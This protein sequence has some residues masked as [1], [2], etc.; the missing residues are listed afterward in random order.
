MTT[1]TSTQTNYEPTPLTAEHRRVLAGSMVGTTIEWFDFFIYAQAA[2]LIFAAQYFNPASNSSPALAQIVSW[3]SIGISFLFRP[4]GAV[5]AG[6]LGDRLGR[7]IVLVLTL[8]G[9]GGAT[10]AMGLLPN[11]AA[12]GIAAPL[13]LVVLRIIQGLSAGGE[14]GGA[15]LLAVE[16]APVNR[17][18]YFGSYPQVGVPAGMFLATTF[19]LV[20]TR[21][22]T[23]EQF[24]A[25]G[26]RIPFLSSIVMIGIGYFIR[27]MV[28]ESPVFAELQN[29]QK[30][31]SAPLS[32]LFKRHTK[33]VFIAAF[34]F[35]GCNAAGYLA[36]AFFNSYGTKV[37]HLPKS[38]VLFVSLLS[39]ITWL[40]GTL[41]S[42]L[43]GDKI[44]KRKTFAWAYVAMIIYAV[45]MWLLIDTKSIV[46]FA[47]AALILGI[48]L[49]ATYGPQSALYAEM[50][51]AD[52][53][54]SGVSISYAI[55][56]IFGGAF[57]PMIAQMLLNKTGSSLSIGVYI[58]GVSL[59]SLIAVLLVPKEVE[60]RSLH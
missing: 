22:T 4:L 14:W 32:V 16:H 49:G 20:L 12:I 8:F 25:W 18:S 10:V 54:L 7:K 15:A 52:I 17:R 23:D 19:M 27:R 43:L 24:N 29:L 46:L 51:P 58:A 6:H 48:L 36:I 2:G 1:A 53:R 55:G 44:G 59:L 45:P 11:Y 42:G 39:S 30:E 37:L 57:A 34:I 40:I 35:S 56:S 60:G 13:L 26:W 3:A 47:I 50:F 31:S 28:E 21:V 33:D 5:I 9:M 38:Q 41:W